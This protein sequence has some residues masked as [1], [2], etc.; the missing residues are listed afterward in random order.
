MA[1]SEKALDRQKQVIGWLIEQVDIR[2]WQ[3][4]PRGGDSRRPIDGEVMRRRVYM[5]GRQALVEPNLQNVH[6]LDS[7][8]NWKIFLREMKLDSRVFYTTADMSHGAWGLIAYDEDPLNNRPSMLER[9]YKCRIQN[10]GQD[11]EVWIPELVSDFPSFASIPIDNVWRRFCVGGK[12]DDLSSDSTMSRLS[13]SLFQGVQNHLTT[14]PGVFEYS[15]S[16]S[17]SN[18]V[19]R[20]VTLSGDPTHRNARI[21]PGNRLTLVIG[22]NLLTVK[23]IAE[24]DTESFYTWVVTVRA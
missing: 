18:L 2:A 13:V 16:V 11:N 4:L 1:L 17:G 23:C 19:G 3:E 14:R 5:I 6:I 10:Y 12:I 21:V 22:V 24:D 15:S 20:V 7:D 8:N 9:F